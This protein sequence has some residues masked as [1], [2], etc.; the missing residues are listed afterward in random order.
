MN[1]LNH[2]K[3]VFFV[4]SIAA[5]FAPQALLAQH[6]GH[7]GGGGGGFHGGGGGGFHGGGARPAPAGGG[8]HDAAP[9]SING[10]MRNFG[11]HPM[12]AI[13]RGFP[14]RGIPHP[15]PGLRNEGVFHNSFG[16]RPYA[17][18][19]YHPYVWGRYWHP[20]GFFLG[21]LTAD[22]ILLN[23]DGGQYY[24]DQGVYYQPSNGGYTAVAP[25]IG[26]VVTYLPDGYETV[27]MDNGTYYYY[28]GVFYVQQ[29]DNSFRVVPAP[30]GAIVSEIPQGATQQ[31]INGESYLLYN[32][33]YYLPI[34]QDGQDAYQVVQVG[35]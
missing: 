24:Y 35:S 12:P 25:P 11:N 5:L 30:A 31:N 28:G 4:F 16:F 3:F 21:A 17:Y 15:V 27:P 19:P 8:F 14:G 2:I 6:F 29:G 10:G 32:N 34:S 1:R 9:R 26:A 13:G 33:S 7:G 20:F 22:A 23:F 18:H